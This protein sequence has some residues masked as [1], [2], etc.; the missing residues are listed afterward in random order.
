MRL[1]LPLALVLLLSLGASA[2]PR[3]WTLQKSSARARFTVEAPLDAI[4]GASSGL[5]GTLTFAEESW[6][7]SAGRIR[8]DLT[9]FTTG[10]SLRDEDLRDQFFQ[11]DKFPEATLIITGIERVTVSA[12]TLDTD[13][14]AD[15]VGTLS[16]H[17]QTRP[18]RI[19]ITVRLT[20]SGGT[21]Q[22]LVRGNFDVTMADYAISRPAR[23]FLKLGTVA[24]VNFEA[25]FSAAS[26]SSVSRAV[27]AGAPE[28][29]AV[30]PP[31]PLPSPPVS[32]NVVVARRTKGP[33][34][35]PAWDFAL[36]S[37]E[38]RGERLFRD[39][40]VGS[41]LNANSCWSCHNVHDERTG[42]FDA[43][44]HVRSNSTLWDS[45]RR[46]SY[47]RGFAENL[48]QGIDICVRKFM[49]KPSGAAKEQL[50]DLAAY[51]RRISPD[52]QPPL[53]YGALVL[54]RAT[55]IDRPTGGNA[56]RGAVLVERHCSYCH[57]EGA[58]RPPLTPG[59][60]EADYLVKRVRWIPGHD[61]KQMPPM[62]MDRLRDSELRDIVT[63]LV[64][65]DSTRIFR[66]KPKG[67]IAPRS[68]ALRPAAPIAVR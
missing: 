47:W 54:G 5:S 45:G 49:L 22:M 24:Q 21:R 64:G 3:L 62:A 59:L 65:D 40:T 27:A 36:T 17:G 43:V 46:S 2:E 6:A 55:A 12:L 34:R 50:A 11:V 56:E 19:P 25:S 1:R 41:E 38:G 8:I 23:L 58:L 57:A 13:A 10:L 60:Y 32:L 51:L 52:V 7:S 26:P 48:E 30:A 66:R 31:R 35:A 18:V 68:E 63:Y 20:E 16:L 4:H 33:A 29:P 53:D 39:P 42:F 15:A 67:T 28:T 9:G 14:Q 44:G 61:A 37:A